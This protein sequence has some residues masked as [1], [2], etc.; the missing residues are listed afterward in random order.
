MGILFC[1]SDELRLH[2]EQIIM[3]RKRARTQRDAQLVGFGHLV[4]QAAIGQARE[5]STAA[6]L[7]PGHYR[8]DQLIV[9]RCFD[10]VTEESFYTKYSFFPEIFCILNRQVFLFVSHQDYFS[11][12][13]N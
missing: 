8:R 13:K 10:R 12:T 5:F 7:I 11:N 4:I 3:D 2:Y 6:T 1:N 9:F